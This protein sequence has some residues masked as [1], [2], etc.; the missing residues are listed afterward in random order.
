MT[1]KEIVQ[2]LRCIATVCNAP[3][4]WAENNNMDDQEE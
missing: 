2:A 3:E 4:D 1:E